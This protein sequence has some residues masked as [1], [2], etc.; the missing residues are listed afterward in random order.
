M[1]TSLIE[2]LWTSINNWV[3]LWKQLR[4]CRRHLLEQ[5]GLSGETIWEDEN[6]YS[7]AWLARDVKEPTLTTESTKEFPVLWWALGLTWIAPFPLGQ[8]HPRNIDMFMS[9]YNFAHAFICYEWNS[10]FILP[11]SAHINWWGWALLHNKEYSWEQSNGKPWGGEWLTQKR[12]NIT[13]LLIEGLLPSP[14]T[15]NSCC[16]AGYRHCV[17]LKEIQVQLTK[18]LKVYSW[19]L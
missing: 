14:A 5:F 12:D 13:E 1:W 17:M 18:N 11:C 15:P 10:F 4:T 6:V 3:V 7:A 16:I 2:L 8:K 19:F 9:T